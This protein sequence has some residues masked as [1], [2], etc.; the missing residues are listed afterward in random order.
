MLTPTKRLLVNLNVKNYRRL[1]L[2]YTAFLYIVTLIP[3]DIIESDSVKWW[4]IIKFQN[5]DKIVHFLLFF[6]FTWLW[7]KA[8][9]PK[10]FFLFLF[11]F[12]T[13][14]LIETL[15]FLMH[16]GRTFDLWDIL[17]NT[18]GIIAMIICIKFYDNRK[19]SETKN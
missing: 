18:I 7:F 8:Y 4:H 17:A 6:C 5:Q 11:P 2:F 19:E 10:L 15:Q 12:L 16:E 1:F 14:V 13:G 9:Q 3:T